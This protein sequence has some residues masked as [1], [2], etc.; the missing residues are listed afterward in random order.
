MVDDLYKAYRKVLAQ[1]FS[2]SALPVDD[3]LVRLVFAA[4]DGLVFQQTALGGADNTR[5]ALSR[6]RDILNGLKRQP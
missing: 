1:E 2:C 4:L 6:L 5:D 3:A